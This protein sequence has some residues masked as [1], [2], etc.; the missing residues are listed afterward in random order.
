MRCAASTNG[1]SEFACPVA[2]P[3]PKVSAAR[4]LKDGQSRSS[5]WIS[6]NG[7]ADGARGGAGGAGGA[8]GSDGSGGSGGLP[9]G[10]GNR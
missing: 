9:G 1:T 5:S 6:S 10:G 4:R 8:G 7:S 3:R 2:T